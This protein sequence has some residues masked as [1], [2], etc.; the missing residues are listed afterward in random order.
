MLAVLSPP[1]QLFP[2]I[3]ESLQAHY[4]VLQTGPDAG[5]EAGA[6]MLNTFLNLVSMKQ[7]AGYTPMEAVH[8]LQV[9]PQVLLGEVIQ[10]PRIYQTLHEVRAVLRQTQAG[11]P[12]VPN[13]LV[14]HVSVCQSLQGDA[15]TQTLTCGTRRGCDF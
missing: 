7:Q 3:I 9:A 2:V 14:I 10:H 5:V 13:P 6:Q 11:Q 12:L 15:E 8:H 1:L 4:P